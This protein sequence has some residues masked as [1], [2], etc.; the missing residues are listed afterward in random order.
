M[1]CTISEKES[2][3]DLV[4]Q[5]LIDG[6]SRQEITL[7]AGNK[8]NIKRA[9]VDNYIQEM[10]K[11]RV[12]HYQKRSADRFSI[13]MARLEDAFHRA[14]DLGDIKLEKDIVAL[15]MKAEEHLVERRDIQITAKTDKERWLEQ[16]SAG[17]I[18]EVLEGKSIKIS[19]GDHNLQHL[20]VLTPS[21]TSQATIVSNEIES[22][23]VEND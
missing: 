10:N 1:G 17:K 7:L 14:K 4:D 21:I 19:S 15:V 2:R 13:H 11:R 16:Q 9:Q 12:E 3:L 20:D 8:W 18:V 6:K 5:W 22:E 23:E